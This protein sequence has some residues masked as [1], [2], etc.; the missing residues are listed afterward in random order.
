MR[1]EHTAIW[2]HDL[3]RLRAFYERYFGAEASS[4]YRSRTRTGFTSSFLTFP[5]GGARLELMSIAELSA[6]PAGDAVGYAHLAVAVGSR[7]AVDALTA[8]MWEDGVRVVGLPRETGDGYYESVVND[9][10]GNIVEIT[11]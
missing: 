7:A 2:T 11:V 9:P 3:A 6:A 10:D 4:L 1:L 8:R 5:G